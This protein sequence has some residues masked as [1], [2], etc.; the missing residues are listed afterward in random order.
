MR[1]V[2]DL[3]DGLVDDGR[4]AAGRRVP[5]REA[6]FVAT[7]GPGTR[8]GGG[9]ALLVD[10][11][12][13][14]D[15]AEAE[16]GGGGFGGDGEIVGIFAGREI[17]FGLGGYGEGWVGDGVMARGDGDGDGDGGVVSEG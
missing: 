8:V 1:E 10:G 17:G 3:R 13:A 4:G 2:D 9:A 12:A 6:G 5:G 7:E 16:A 11:L 15:D 14:F